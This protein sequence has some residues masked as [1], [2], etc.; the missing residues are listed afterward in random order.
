MR[1]LRIGSGHALPIKMATPF[2]WGMKAAAESWGWGG[3][4]CVARRPASS[5]S[6]KDSRA[7]KAPGAA[8]RSWAFSEHLYRYS[9]FLLYKGAN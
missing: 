4:C 2:L 9:L 7:G 6:S 1:V 8:R 5:S 3:G